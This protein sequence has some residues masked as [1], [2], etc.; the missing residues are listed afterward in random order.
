MVSSPD[1]TTTDGGGSRRDSNDKND[2]KKKGQVPRTLLLLYT[3][4]FVAF[5]VH[6]YTDRAP[7]PVNGAIT[8]QQ[9]RPGG[10]PGAAA[11]VST[12]GD[13]GGDSLLQRQHQ[14][15]T[16]ERSSLSTESTLVTAQDK[17]ERDGL[18]S[19]G[20]G[21][22]DDGCDGLSVGHRVARNESRRAG[23]STGFDNKTRW[24]EYSPEQLIQYQEV[25]ECYNRINVDKKRAR[26]E[27]HGHGRN[28]L[29]CSNDNKRLNVGRIEDTG[30]YTATNTTAFRTVSPFLEQVAGPGAHLLQSKL[31]GYDAV[32]FVGDS[33]QRQTY[34]AFV[35][36]L[37][38]AAEAENVPGTPPRALHRYKHTLP[39]QLLSSATT[40]GVGTMRNGTVEIGYAQSE[41]GTGRH[42]ALEQLILRYTGN[43]PDQA[44]VALNEDPSDKSFAIVTNLA[45]FHYHC[46]IPGLRGALG[47]RETA[48]AV[49]SAAEQANK[50]VV[51]QE[52]F[53]TSICQMERTVSGRTSVF[54]MEAADEQWPTSNGVYTPSCAWKCQC[55]ALTVDRIEGFGKLEDHSANKVNISQDALAA[56]P[57]P[58]ASRDYLASLYPELDFDDEAAK[59]SPYCVPANWR[60]DVAIPIILGATNGSD[61]I[62]APRTASSLRVV[63]IWR[64]L[65]SRGQRN[66]RYEAGDC[67]HKSLSALIAMNQQLVRTIVRSPE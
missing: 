35:C 41:P 57:I 44:S 6:V 12:P 16:E 40:T 2:K 36:M 15:F 5:V 3:F 14:F 59:C 20:A 52:G 56:A 17:Q 11:E 65:V 49:V 50:N 18:G 33:V 61:N 53:K 66:S 30:T 67:T 63:P 54:V 38:P 55:E 1:T 27:D 62:A 51:M 25:L 22:E 60:N 26:K 24:L 28:W 21:V 58:M 43:H 34:A 9:E 8:V 31:L 64:Q 23:V 7:G 29:Y 10:S 47:L 46:N 19:S 32:W 4:V 39:P 48:R 13:G 37:N 45:A 42:K